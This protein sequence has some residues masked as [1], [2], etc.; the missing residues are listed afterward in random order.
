[1]RLILVIAAFIVWIS[2]EAKT[3]PNIIYITADDM[4]YADLS[5]Y[6][7]TMFKTPQLDAMAM[8]GMVFRNAYVAAPVCTPSRTALMTG[9]YP[10]RVE[11]GLREP[12]DW[13]GD[14][15]LI[16]LNRSIPNLAMQLNKAGYSTHLVGKWHL[17]F[18]SASFPLNNGF[19]SFYGLLGGANDY[20]S[21]TTPSGQ[22]DFY[23][24]FS[25]C[26]DQGYMTDLLAKRAI[27]IIKAKHEKPFFLSLQ[28]TAPH[29]PWQAPGDSVYPKGNNAWKQGGS[30]EVFKRMVQS[31][32]SAIG[33]VLAAVKKSGLEKNT[34]IIFTSDNGGERYSDMGPYKNR[35]MSLWE[36]G[37][38]IPAIVYWPGGATTTRH[39]DQPIINMDWSATFYAIAGIKPDPESDGISLLPLL[40]GNNKMIDRVFVWRITQRANQKAVRKGN[41]KYLIAESG[42]YIFNLGTDPYE[43]NNLI[44]TETEKLKEMKAILAQWE[45]K[46]LKPLPAVLN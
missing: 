16:G 24:G 38:K 32:D 31:M 42:E 8:Q 2:T 25:V 4:G 18:S 36:G 43:S 9:R 3:K 10:A 12:I 46:M 33:E 20:I 22:L 27:D 28:F 34:I 29:W 19:D 21:H 39:I 40:K 35:K 17:G 1:M 6:G 41:W 37:I 11:V 15:S 23:D 13:T 26:K 30:K 7:N 5:C 14:D 44:H 45:A